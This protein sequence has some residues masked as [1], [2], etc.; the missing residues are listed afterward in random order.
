MTELRSFF[1]LA[2]YYRQ[3]V[4]GF[5]RIRIVNRVG[6][7]TNGVGPQC[8]VAFEG[9]KKSMMERPVLGTANVIKP[10]EVE[11]DVSNFALGGVLF[12]DGHPI[13]CKSKK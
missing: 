6:K 4:E 1:E 10:F 7:T 12:Q 11:T 8:Q 13:A 9:L 5:S 3:F 2:N